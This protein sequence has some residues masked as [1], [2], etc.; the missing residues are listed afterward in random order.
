LH[1]TV[2]TSAACLDA[3]ANFLIE[4]GSSGVVLKRRAV[5]AYFPNDRH[6]GALKRAVQRFVLDV[7]KLQGRRSQPRIVWQ[8]AR[9][10][11]WQNRWKRFIRPSRVGKQFW[12][13]PPWL[14]PPK[15]RSR[16]VITIEPGMA[17]G[18]GT[19]ATTRGC[20]EFIE[21]VAALIPGKKFT[22][23]D[24]GTGSAILAIALAK[25]GA[26]KIWAIDND[27]VAVAV[28]RD[29]LRIN[30]VAAQVRLSGASLHCIQQK[31]P[32][33]VG[34]LTAETIIDLAGAMAQRVA[35]GGYLILSGILHDKAAAV[36]ACFTP[37]F[38]VVKRKRGREW[39]T[40][41]LRR[42]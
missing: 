39:V 4:R 11:N 23:L 26:R 25:L 17:F 40:L 31:F 6:S 22:A 16:Q 2:H 42:R 41:L 38:Q 18:T 13:T 14:N 3:V 10:E 35:A 20:L 1:L 27:P 21:Q 28:A 19:H 37:R 9:P 36:V 5:E 12:V 7:V 15:F 32:L 24:V 34:N 30:H 33:V 8:L 29:N